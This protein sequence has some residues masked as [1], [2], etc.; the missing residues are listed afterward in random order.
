LF[1]YAIISIWRKI[2]CTSCSECFLL[3]WSLE[4]TGFFIIMC[5]NTNVRLNLSL[6]HITSVWRETLI[7]IS[8]NKNTFIH[9]S[10]FKFKSFFQLGQHHKDLQSSHEYNTFVC[11]EYTPCYIW[12]LNF[13]NGIITV[14]FRSRVG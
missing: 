10:F 13:L 14:T 3:L 4:L 8:E 7:F 12:F 2:K 9:N 5:M 1:G 6:Y 11:N